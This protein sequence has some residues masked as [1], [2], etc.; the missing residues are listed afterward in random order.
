MRGSG[1]LTAH[2]DLGHRRLE[3]AHGHR[4]LHLLLPPPPSRVNKQSDER[5]PR[6][7]RM[8][9]LRRT[10]ESSRISAGVLPS[11]AR[12]IAI[13]EASRQMLVMSAPE[14]VDRASRAAS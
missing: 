2:L 6:P 4:H 8:R 7:Q 3:V 5:T 1:V 14:Y 12:R 9:G 10:C 13:M 11:I